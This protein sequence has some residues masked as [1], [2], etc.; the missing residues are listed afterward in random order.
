MERHGATLISLSGAVGS[1]VSGLREQFP[2]NAI[3]TGPVIVD[4]EAVT[5]LHRAGFR[6]LIHELD[7]FSG[8]RRLCVVCR[9]PSALRLLRL[10]DVDHLVPVFLTVDG[11]LGHNPSP[12][13]PDTGDATGL[14][15]H[16]HVVEFYERDEFLVES[17]QQFLAPALR[18]DDAVIVVAT[19]RHRDMF[20]VALRNAGLDVEGART[21]DRYVGLDAED[22]LSSFMVEGVPH[23]ARFE[24]TMAGLIAKAGNHGRKVRVYG[25]MVA[26]LWAAGNVSAA[27]ALEDLWNDLGRARQFQLFCA[28]PMAGFD[29]DDTTGSFHRICAQHTSVIPTERYSN[30][31]DAEQRVRAVALMQ[32]EAAAAL[33]ER[34]RLEAR[35][36]ELEQLATTDPL[37]GL[38][39]QRFFLGQ[40]DRALALARREAW[41]VAVLFLDLDRFKAVNH[42]LGHR[43]G[44]LLL[45]EVGRRLK[46]ALRESDTVAR[47]G[48]DEFA[49]LL[50]GPTSAQEAAAAARRV[51]ESFR[52]GFDADGAVLSVSCSVGVSR[53]SA[54]G[55]SAAELLHNADLAMYRAK[56]AGGDRFEMF[57][58]GEVVTR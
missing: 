58:P 38:A 55:G 15:P 5:L 22:M 27:I 25:E 11:A 6:Q 24:A 42:R 51:L 48:G 32:Q 36:R 29:R 41:D 17:V 14:D 20:E 18:A 19:K 2:P 28:Y 8:E 9:R 31:E 16:G 46:G 52:A 43:F 1:D 40:L 13:A 21:A 34:T 30:L 45:V 35:V 53:C 33:T 4:I 39:N 7:A 56:D 23:P 47:L 12:V 49:V 44:D 54:G 50:S 37:T 57:Q 26:V 10:W 3:G